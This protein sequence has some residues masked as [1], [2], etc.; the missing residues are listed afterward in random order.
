VEALLARV[1]DRMVDE[2]SCSCGTTVAGVAVRGTR[3]L[4][5][6]AGDSRVYRVSPGA[7]ERLTRDH[8]YVQGCVDRGEIAEE[9]AFSHPYRNV[10]EFGLGDIFAATWE[11]REREVFVAEHRLAPG[12]ALLLCSDGLHDALRDSELRGALGASPFEGVAGFPSRLRGIVRDNTSY[13]LV[14]PVFARHAD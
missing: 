3:A 5:F 11:Q 7:I 2:L 12:D 1:Q 9:E 14:E 8:S 4:V 10:I 13:I 6:S